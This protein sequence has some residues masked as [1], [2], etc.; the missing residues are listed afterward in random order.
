M[1]TRGPS[2][3][4]CVDTCPDPCV[5]TKTLIA[6]EDP[7]AIAAALLLAETDAPDDDGL[8]RVRLKAPIE[9][10]TPLLRALMRVEAQLL[11]AD[12]ADFPG[13]EESCRTE[14][15]RRVAALMQ[16]VQRLRVLSAVGR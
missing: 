5:V 10:L 6:G 15:E 7:D 12:A 8:V 13:T 11:L 1:S 2:D 9:T 3:R 14:G 16:I 4:H